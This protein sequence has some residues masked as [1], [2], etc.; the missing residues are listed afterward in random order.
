[1]S[2]ILV[3]DD[4]FAICE[5]LVDLLELEGF[6]TLAAHNGATGIAL[7]QQHL[8]DLVLCDIMMPGLDGYQVLLALRDDPLT[9]NIPLIFLTAKVDRPSMRYGMVL[10][11]DDYL[12]KPFEAEE[13]IKTINARLERHRVMTE[14]YEK[15]MHDL[16][17]NIFSMLP[18]ELRTPLMTIMGYADLLL[19]DSPT[20]PPERVSEMAERI[21]AGSSRLQHLI[22]NFLVYAQIELLQSNPDRVAAAREHYVYAPD[23]ITVDIA[24]HQ[25]QKAGREDDLQL[26]VVAVHKIQVALESIRKIIDELI[27]NA[28]KFS[29]PGTPVEVTTAIVDGTYQWTIRDQ[30]RGMTPDQI[31]QIGAGMQFERRLFEQQGAGLGLI[32]SRRMITLYGGTFAIDSEPGVQTTIT[33]ALPVLDDE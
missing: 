23:A 29:M 4:E 12:T 20:L 13:L 2:T 17:G 32:I 9:V 18:H 10:G 27:D 5:N 28:F 16:R 3:I 8:P 11:A 21:L 14:R 33:F 22:E 25:A 1:M 26:D 7:A 31:A 6:A 19:W 24:Q 30:G 15:A